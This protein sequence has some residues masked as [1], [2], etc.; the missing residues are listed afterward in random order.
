MARGDRRESLN[1]RVP[2]DV[3]RRFEV[4]AERVDTSINVA[5]CVLLP[6]GLRA[7]RRRER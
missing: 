1:L 2:P 3:K 5:V 4:R 7:E 6:E